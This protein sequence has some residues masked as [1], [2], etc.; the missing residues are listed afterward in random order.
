MT[1][2]YLLNILLQGLHPILTHYILLS[3]V[4]F[5]SIETTKSSK[6]PTPSGWACLTFTG[7]NNIVVIYFSPKRNTC[8]F[9]QV[10]GIADTWIGTNSIPDNILYDK[11]YAEILRHNYEL[12]YHKFPTLRYTNEWP[13]SGTYSSPSILVD[14]SWLNNPYNRGAK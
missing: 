14:K 9:F 5:V 13:V 8:E 12:V 4:Q 1:K 2:N 10:K 3:N 7:L 11:N 6:L